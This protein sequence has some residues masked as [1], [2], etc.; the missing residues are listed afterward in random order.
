[1]QNRIAL[2]FSD[3][4][5][6]K[7]FTSDFNQNRDFFHIIDKDTEETTEVEVKQLKAIFFVKT[8]EGNKD[9]QER[10][11]VE[12]TGLG[13]KIKVR[14]KD[15]ETIVGYTTGYSPDRSGFFL[16]PADGQNNNERIYVIRAASD[17]ILFL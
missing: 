4:K 5:I 13:K 17:E 6:A 14:F 9:Y 8:F 11:D 16:F 1:M 15:G 7:G 10:Q 12:R 3:G 2:H